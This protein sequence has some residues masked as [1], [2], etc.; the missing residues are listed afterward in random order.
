MKGWTNSYCQVVNNSLVFIL[1]AGFCC[2]AFAQNPVLSIVTDKQSGA[3][4]KHGLT[5]LTEALQAK[6][7][8][9]EQV[10]SVRAAR[11]KWILVT[12]LANGAGP[13]AQACKAGKHNVPQVPEALAIWQTSRNKSPIWVVSGFDDPGLMYGLL[14]VAD[15]I[16]WSTNAAAPLSEVRAVNEQPEVQERGV[17][18]YTM[19]RAYWESRLYD[20]AYWARYL[21]LLARDRFNSLVII[22]GYENG[23]F[24]GPCY[25]YFCDVPGFPDVKMVGLTQAQQQHNL[26][27]FNTLIKMAHD[28]GIAVTTGFQ[29][30]IYSGGVQAGGVPGLPV[31]PGQPVDGQVAGVTKTN[32][33]AYTRA[34]LA[35]FLKVVP[36]LDGVLFF[37]NNETGL[38]DSELL[39]FASN[40]FQ[41]MHADGSGKKIYVHSKGFTDAMIQKAADAGVKI[42]IS[43]KY[44]M[45]QMGMPFHPTHINRENQFDRRHGYADLLRYPRTYDFCWRL[46]NGGTTRILLWGDPEYARRFVAST[47]LYDSVGFDVNEP[48]ATKMEAQPHDQKPFDLLNPR[49]RYYDYEFERYWHFYQVFGRLGYN[50]ATSPEVWQ[51]EFESRFGKA[52]PLVEAALHRASWILP[53]IVASCYPYAC[54]PTTRGWPEKQRLG[55]LPQY[56]KAEGSDIAQ[57]ANFDEEAQLLITGGETAKTLPSTTSRW[58]EQTSADINE[59]IAQ[60]ET[61]I[62][63]NRNKE[64]DSTITDLKILS[65]L[66]LYHSR[67]IPAAVSYCLFDRTKDPAALDAA[68]AGERG[69]LDAWSQLV[70]AAGDVY[71][72]DLMMG[73]RESEFSGINQHLSG[74]WR[75]ELGY[76]KTGLAA[77][78]EQ[79]RDLKPDATFKPA[80]HYQP[81]SREDYE[82]KF[83]INHDPIMTAPLG[84]PLIITARVS[85]P[86]GI[87]W[88]RLRCRSVNQKQ[89]YQTLPML[90]TSAKDTYQ[91][92]LP[93]AI[94]N[95]K[96][97]FMYYLEVMDNHGHGRIY[98]DFNE[99]AP[100]FI[101]KLI[102]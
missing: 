91:A 28:R 10:G 60:A 6:G 48:L 67:R 72:D 56:A 13:A 27:A 43:P 44:W 35:K 16:G 82:T 50:P 5:K 49:Y 37:L 85:A 12:G 47:H 45:E 59:L 41:V 93:A 38:N 22:F 23:G 88:V 9:Y 11:G 26:A 54:F 33:T 77:L 18:M 65:N 32:L 98:P 99:T 70:T 90:P 86:A 71:A 2:G 79:R 100:Y 25:P 55:D 74:H 24:L 92:V 46:W 94:L 102:R 53:R 3:P 75:D 51:R 61:V 15:R 64:F 7:I 73:I 19:N 39:D 97:D 63:T 34:A 83:S 101:V 66:A 68:I 58:L 57:F 8:S 20:E 31:V 69:A 40:L 84:K 87:K 21:D 4:A 62:G 89:D 29:S 80:P 42:I 17:S 78:E 96:W 1:I 76:L 36:D 81:M 95:P 14:D 30:H 52:A